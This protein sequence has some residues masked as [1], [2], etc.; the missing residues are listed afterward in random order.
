MKIKFPKRKIKILPHHFNFHSEL[1][2]FLVLNYLV[3][4][5]DTAKVVSEV[6]SKSENSAGKNSLGGINAFFS[7]VML[8]IPQDEVLTLFFAKMQQSKAFSIFFAQLSTADYEN[9]FENLKV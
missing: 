1:F 6:S 8:L 5:G 7:E 3:N 2:L 9:L 4:E